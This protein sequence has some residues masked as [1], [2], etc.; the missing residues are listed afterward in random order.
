MAGRVKNWWNSLWDD[1]DTVYEDESS[2]DDDLWADLGIDPDSDP[3][4]WFDPPTGTVNPWDIGETYTKGSDEWDQIMAELSDYNPNI[5]GSSGYAGGG[6][7]ADDP[8]GIGSLFDFDTVSSNPTFDSTPNIFD[9]DWATTYDFGDWGAPPVDF[10][11]PDFNWG[12]FDVDAYLKSRLDTNYGWD[13]DP[14]TGMSFNT[15]YFDDPDWLSKGFDDDEFINFLNNFDFDDPKADWAGGINSLR[16]WETDPSGKYSVNVGSI[17]GD[18]TSGFQTSKDYLDYLNK[19]W[20]TGGGGTPAPAASGIFSG[21]R[22]PKVAGFLNKIL[23]GAGTAADTLGGGI[24]DLLNSTLGQLAMLNYMKNKNKDVMDIP[25]GWG[26]G[27]GGGGGDGSPIDYRVFNLQPALM[28]GV[29]YANV[30]KPEG[31]KYGGSVYPSV[32]PALPRPP[33]DPRRHWTPPQ[34]KKQRGYGQA[35]EGRGGMKDGGLGDVTLAKLEPGEFVV[36]KK[37]VDNIGAQ[38]LYKMMKQAEGRG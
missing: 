22:M 20:S 19:D 11:D 25:T 24:G 38:N 2:F 33:F 32:N 37:A 9:D 1:D 4:T 26:D 12:E 27:G 17:L 6:M 3:D 15:G 28:P 5:G 10:E 34:P 36:T 29:A 18:P 8:Y 35:Q 21:K 14:E 7:P 13:T 31:M 30:G 16:G 23:G